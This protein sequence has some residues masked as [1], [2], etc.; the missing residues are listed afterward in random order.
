[1]LYSKDRAIG[2]GISPF[3]V[4]L[5]LGNLDSLFIVCRGSNK[6]KICPLLTAF[7]LFLWHSFHLIIRF[8][9]PAGRLQEFH[10]FTSF[11]K[12]AM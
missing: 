7:G 8:V 3:F 9:A 5:L 6:V 12:G 10:L 2:S 11:S 1:M 4:L